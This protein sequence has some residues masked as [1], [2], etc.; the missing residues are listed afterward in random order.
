[1]PFVNEATVNS[2]IKANDLRYCY[3]VFGED[4]YLKKR[5][6][7]KLSSSVADKDDFFNFQQFDNDSS[8]QEVYDSLQ[9]YPMMSDK[10]CVILKDYNFEDCEKE[11]FDRLIQLCKDDVPTA[12]FIL[13]FDFTEFDTKKNEKFKKLCAAAEKGNARVVDVPYRSIAELSKM[14]C[15][16]AK[17]R[18]CTLAYDT[19]VFMVQTVGTE[20]ETLQN[21][22][23]KV[24]AYV[25]SGEI[26]ER[27]VKNVCIQTIEQSVYNLSGNILSG[28]VSAALKV[29]DELFFMRVQPM[30]IFYTVAG[31]YVDLC[32]AYGAREG[33]VSVSQAVKDFSYKNKSFLLERAARQIGKINKKRLSLS[34]NELMETDKRFKSNGTDNREVLEEMIVRLSYIATEG[35]SI[36]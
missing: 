6:V 33:G 9:Q 4:R 16:G 31:V 8:L 35:K 2:D 22:L 12:V 25:G 26:T 15:D 27:E 36:D 10:K 19:A 7:E 34:L 18:G 32:R 28:N 20:I 23:E 1:M 14:L 30:A 11:D 5:L 24:C 21:E 17:K 3:V 13:W 29:L